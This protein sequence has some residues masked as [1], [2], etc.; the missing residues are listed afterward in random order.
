[1]IAG[2][3][4]KTPDVAGKKP[5]GDKDLGIEKAANNVAQDVIQKNDKELQ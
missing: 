3:G 1:M 2:K 5:E 4:S